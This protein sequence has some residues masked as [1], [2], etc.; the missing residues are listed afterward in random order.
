MKPLSYRSPYLRKALQSNDKALAGWIQFGHQKMHFGNGSEEEAYDN[1][2]YR[3]MIHSA[4]KNVEV[5][6]FG[7]S[8]VDK[9]VEGVYDSYDQLPEWMRDRLAGLSILPIP[10][11]PQDVDG[12][13]TRI[14]GNIYWVYHP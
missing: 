13:G 11:P 7:M 4:T 2:T 5:M 14:S 10:P 8:P 1:S 6:C 3:V 12:V 9:S